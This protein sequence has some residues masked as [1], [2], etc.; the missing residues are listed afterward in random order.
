MRDEKNPLCFKEKYQDNEI[1]CIL[2]FKLHIL[3]QYQ[4]MKLKECKAIQHGS[5]CI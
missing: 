2:I 3:Y 1:P 5:C 4:P